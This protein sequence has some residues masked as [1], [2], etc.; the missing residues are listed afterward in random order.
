MRPLGNKILCQPI[1]Q[2]KKAGEIFL[3]E[4]RN[5]PQTCHTL[6]IAV[7]PKVEYVKVG[8]EIVID[9]YAQDTARLTVEGV[10]LFVVKEENVIAIFP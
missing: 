10:G 6:V 1:A 9:R 8:N 7:G 3:P 2:P 4:D 5:K